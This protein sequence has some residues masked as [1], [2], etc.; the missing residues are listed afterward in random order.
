MP[1]DSGVAQ[2]ALC[3]HPVQSTHANL[4]MWEVGYDAEMIKD[5]APNGHFYAATIEYGALS[6]RRPAIAPMRRAIDQHGA[7]I[8]EQ[9]KNDLMDVIFSSQVS[10]QAS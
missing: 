1:V 5:N 2:E 9:M 3:V 4:F 7:E 6:L 8:I 10:V